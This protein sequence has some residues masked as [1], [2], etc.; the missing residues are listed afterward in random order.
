[1]MCPGRLISAGYTISFI[2]YAP[3]MQ[4]ALRYTCTA[5]P[6]NDR[7]K[8]RWTNSANPSTTTRERTN[9]P[10]SHC[11][12][13]ISLVQE[14]MRPCCGTYRPT[15]I[16]SCWRAFIA[17]IGYTVGNSLA[18]RFLY[19]CT[20]RSTCITVRSSNMRPTFSEKHI[21]GWKAGC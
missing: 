7:L 21:S 9:D 6:A 15:T 4:R 8:K 3:C 19:V 13:P 16:P 20:I 11:N 5:S 10:L 12:Y 17:P 18:E 1:M 14:R 2:R